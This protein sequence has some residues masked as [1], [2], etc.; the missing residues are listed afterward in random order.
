MTNQTPEEIANN[1][2]ESIPQRGDGERWILP[3][4]FEKEIAKAIQAE[5][6]VA[7]K[8][9]SIDGQIRD[10]TAQTIVL[11]SE[12][13]ELR[14]ELS[15]SKLASKTHKEAV[16]ELRSALRE[17]VGVLEKHLQ[18]IPCTCEDGSGIICMPC[19]DGERKLLTKLKPLIQ[20]GGGDGRD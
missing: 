4:K 16:E 12:I 7:E 9:A 2:V 11:S 10:L 1:L 5:R 8:D 20:D 17:A 19:L 13:D 6:D 14:R 18:Q 15:L 3:K